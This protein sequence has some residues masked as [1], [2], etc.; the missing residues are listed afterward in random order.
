[1]LTLLRLARV[2][3]GVA[4]KQV[5]DL[6]TRWGT[7]VVPVYIWKPERFLESRWSLVQ[8]DESLK[9]L[10]QQRNRQQQ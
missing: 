10:E 7:S 3:S 9:M 8:D 4:W 5:V 2:P 1:M 6:P